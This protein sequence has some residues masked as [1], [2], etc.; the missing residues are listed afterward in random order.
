MKTAVIFYSYGGNCAFVAAHIKTL[1]NADLIRLR[2]KNEK[3]R[4]RVTGFL[5]ACAM[6]FMKRRPALKPVAF[7][8]AAYDLIVIG[9]PVWAASPAPPVQA[10]LSQAGIVGK[11]LALFVSHVGGMG[12]ALGKFAA[13][14]PGNEML[15]AKDFTNPAKNAEDTE[16]QVADWVKVLEEKMKGHS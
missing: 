2:T 3:R 8:L 9:A 4:G 10:F 15:D 7:D 1:M 6:V 12:N 13:M 11:K 16:R 14:L 5:T